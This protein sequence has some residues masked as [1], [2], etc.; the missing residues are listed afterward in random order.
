MRDTFHQGL[1]QY[2]TTWTRAPNT[3]RARTEST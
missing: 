3:L 1:S 2:Q